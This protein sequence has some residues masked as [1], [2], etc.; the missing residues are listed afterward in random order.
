MALTDTAIRTAK[1]AEKPRKLADEKGMYLLIQPSGAK[2]WRMD[3]P[4]NGG[5]T[6]S[7]LG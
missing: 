5:R 6:A 7:L 4:I 2:L 1:P 3:Y